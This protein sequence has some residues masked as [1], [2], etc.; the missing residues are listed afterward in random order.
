MKVDIHHVDGKWLN[1]ENNDAD[2]DSISL[3]KIKFL[4]EER[5]KK[6]R[7]VAKLASKSWHPCF[8][9]HNM[10]ILFTAETCLK[11]Y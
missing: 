2:S 4:L 9:L 3:A 8:C 7:N 11:K 1:T 5:K 10:I 6:G